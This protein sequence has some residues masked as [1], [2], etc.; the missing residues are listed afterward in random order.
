MIPMVKA[1]STNSP[2]VEEILNDY[3]IKSF[4]A[5]IAEQSSETAAYSTRSTGTERTLEQDTVD[6]LTS[7]GY[8]AYSET[9]SVTFG[10]Q[11]EPLFTHT[12]TTAIILPDSD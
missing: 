6:T 10:S 7:A 2:T 1:E 9:G 5:K 8:E 4:E 12:R 11:S 3:H